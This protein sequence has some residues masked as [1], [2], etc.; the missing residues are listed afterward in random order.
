[1]GYIVWV[2]MGY[3]IWVNMGYIIWVKA[4]GEVN[5]VFY[6]LI[7]FYRVFS[8]LQDAFYRFKKFKYFF[9][10]WPVKVGPHNRFPIGRE[11]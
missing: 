6:K 11:N 7:L 1:M 3:I 10:I 2:N 4:I 9:E 8:K 5:H